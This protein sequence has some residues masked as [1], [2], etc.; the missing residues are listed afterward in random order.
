ME[1]SYL[2]AEDPAG[3]LLFVHSLIERSESPLFGLAACRIA[4][5]DLH[6]SSSRSHA[7]SLTDLVGSHI[8]HH[9]ILDLFSVQ[10]LLV[11]R[12]GKMRLALEEVIA[13]PSAYVGTEGYRICYTYR[14]GVDVDMVAKVVLKRKK[15]VEIGETRASTCACGGTLR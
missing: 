2:A 13:S 11:Y 12:D 7:S 8:N 9:L 4:E 15:K 5:A 14:G 6:I 3:T 10:A 1:R